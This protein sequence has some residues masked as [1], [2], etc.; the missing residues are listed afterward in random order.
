MYEEH[1]VAVVVPAYN[2]EGFVGDVI[3]TMPAFVDRVYAIDDCSTDD[4]WA[5][6]VRHATVS[7]GV[8]D[9]VA[10]DGDGD[11][12]TDTGTDSQDHDLPSESGAVAD[13]G[14]TTQ[15]G[16]TVVP[17]QNEEN[18]GVGGT[19]KHGYE[20]A[21]ADGMDVTAVMAGDGQMDPDQLD[22][23]LDPIVDGTADYAKGNR[24]S[25]QEYVE[26][27]SSFRLF[28]NFTLSFLTKISSG[29]WGMMDPQN[30]YTAISNEALERIDI[31]NLYEEYG[32]TNDLLV[33][34]NTRQLRVADVSMPAVYGD[35]ESHI[36]YRS[37]VPN[38]SWLLLRRFCRRLGLRYVLTDFHP[39]AFMYLVGTVGAGIALAGLG[40][41]LTARESA[42]SLPGR[43]L[44]TA[45]VAMVSG[46][47][48][49]LAMTFDRAENEDMVVTIE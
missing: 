36:E 11:G 6:I 27:M 39:L 7:S 37:F 4:T 42:D 48:L 10:G 43:L 20:R 40:A 26:E 31:E 23:L 3:E 21:L 12:Y 22:R 14:A 47:C 19:I 24:L 41:A 1:T 44:T 32:F 33:A 38:L 16:P 45:L 28:G 9:A 30:G 2:E 29:Y 35:E 8:P 46:L 34:L 5:E 17:I 13:G 25:G 18:R 15:A 49:L